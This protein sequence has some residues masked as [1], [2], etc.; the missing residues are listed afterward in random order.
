MLETLY[1]DFSTKMLPQIQQGLS[2]TKDYFF[3]LFGRYVK[4]LIIVDSLQVV[5]ALIGFITGIVLLRKGIK[6]GIKEE[7][8][9][10]PYVALILFGSV[11]GIIGLVSFIMEPV[12]VIKDIYIPEIRVMELLSSNIKK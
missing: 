4:Y 8:S 3:D 11:I 2:I 12:D 5:L 6:I 1:N 7:W 9:E 10:G